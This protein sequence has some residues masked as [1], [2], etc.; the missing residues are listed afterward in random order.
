MDMPS[1][2]G[3]SCNKL[4]WAHK[5]A[6]MNPSANAGRCTKGSSWRIA[7]T[8]TSTCTSCRSKAGGAAVG[9]AS[10]SRSAP[11]A[12]CTLPACLK[13]R[14]CRH[15]WSPQ[16]HTSSNPQA[17][18]LADMFATMAGSRIAAAVAPVNSQ[19][20]LTSKAKCGSRRP[21]SQ[22]CSIAKAPPRRIVSAAASAALD[23]GGW[24]EPPGLLLRPCS[25]AATKSALST[26]IPSRTM[27]RIIPGCPAQG[28]GRSLR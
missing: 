7:A 26:Y 20:I 18:S 27:R 22:D 3:Q 15:A 11:V 17:L 10:S 28:S 19:S 25:A 12:S 1:G 13:P 4:R 5:L 9:P 8:P 21:V 16:K 2:G 6:A 14:G 23:D 24:V